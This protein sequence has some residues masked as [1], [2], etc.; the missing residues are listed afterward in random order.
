MSVMDNLFERP[1]VRFADR[2][3]RAVSRIPDTEQVG[4]L[5]IVWNAQDL[6]RLVLV[7]HRRMTGADAQVGGRD[8]H[9]HRGLTDVVLVGHL[10]AL[11]GRYRQDERDRGRRPR[12]MTGTLP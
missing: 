1:T 10:P 2:L 12:D 5:V 6:A 7:P 9:R 11:T 8:H 4:H 3:E